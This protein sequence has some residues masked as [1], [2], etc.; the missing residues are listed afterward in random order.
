MPVSGQAK[1]VFFVLVGLLLCSGLLAT[2]PHV[3]AVLVTEWDETG[4][5]LRLSI[6]PDRLMTEVTLRL[7]IPEMLALTPGAGPFQDRFRE[8]VA[9]EGFRTLEAGLGAIPARSILQL[10]FRPS[11]HETRGGVVAFIVEGQTAGGIQVR[12]AIGVA[13]GH[14]GERPI[15]RHGA[16]EFPA[17]PLPGEPQ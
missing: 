15:R 7:E 1:I 5:T 2:E 9:R 11:G 12:D 16:L 8:R 17:V 3:A 14:P 13:V 4:E 10:S 6:I